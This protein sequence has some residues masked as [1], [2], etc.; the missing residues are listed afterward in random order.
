MADQVVDESGEIVKAKFSQFI[1][2]YE[3]KDLDTENSTTHQRLMSDYKSQISYIIQNDKSTLFVNFQH[4]KEYDFELAEAIELEFYRFEPYLRKSIQEYVSINLRDYGH[5]PNK[6]PREFFVSLH[7]LPRI[8][9]IRTMKTD[10]I[11]RLIC[12]SGTVTRS[13]EVRPEL[14]FGNFTCRKCGTGHASVEQQFQ[15]TEPQVIF[16][17]IFPQIMPNISTYSPSAELAQY[18]QLS[19]Y[20]D[21]QS[22]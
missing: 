18:Y 7:N 15:F 11:G 13:S 14:L 12:I 6:G 9:R 1:S 3:D 4:V 17:L 20:L 10:R 16:F 19:T 22:P 5:D 2:E 21:N 8:E